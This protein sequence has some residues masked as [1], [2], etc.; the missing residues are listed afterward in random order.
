MSDA[1]VT[2]DVAQPGDVLLNI[3]P[4]SAFHQI[5]AIENA[6]DLGEFLFGQILGKPLKLDAELL[7]NNLAVGPTDA[8]EIG[9]ADPNLLL[10]RNINTCDT[11]HVYSTLPGNLA[12]TFGYPCRCLC[13]VLV[14]ITR[15]TPLRR[16]ILQFS[17]IRRTLVR[18][19][20]STSKP[21]PEFGA[22]RQLYTF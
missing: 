7:Q 11:G 2:A 13:L 15:T 3:S 8:V 1:S 21:I 19:F 14:Q 22:N 18:T 9:Q 10:R 20:I 16:T 6:D 4:Q 17:Q 12:K 5:A